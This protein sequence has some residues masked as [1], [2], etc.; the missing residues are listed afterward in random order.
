MI[1]AKEF[2]L[3]SITISV[4]FL[5]ERKK[6]DQPI[7]EVKWSETLVQRHHA[8]A[9]VGRLKE[10]GESLSFTAQISI[11]VFWI[12]KVLSVGRHDP[13]MDLE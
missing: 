1:K 3:P 8:K 10:E 13:K 6:E 12:P 5:H 4:E 7:Q 11:S 9:S 2:K